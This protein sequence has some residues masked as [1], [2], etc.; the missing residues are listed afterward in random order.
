MIIEVGYCE[1]VKKEENKS[2]SERVICSTPVV[3]GD[4]V[5]YIRTWTIDTNTGSYY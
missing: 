3:N 2:K 5:E 1:L 4:I